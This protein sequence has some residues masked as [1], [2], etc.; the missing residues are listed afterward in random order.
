[1]EKYSAIIE[2]LNNGILEFNNFLSQRCH[3]Q[4]INADHILDK[5]ISW[6][7]KEEGWFE[8]PFPSGVSKGLY[9]IFGYNPVN[10]SEKAVYIGKASHEK[11]DIGGRLINHLNNADRDKR[12]YRLRHQDGTDYELE[13]VTT[14]PLNEA[15][16]IASAAEEFLIYHLKSLGVN[17]LNHIGNK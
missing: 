7:L 17:L 12:L 10:S 11:S 1:M 13:F 9:F 16:F 3:L 5:N 15:P 4:T 6:E 14:I 8:R 2:G